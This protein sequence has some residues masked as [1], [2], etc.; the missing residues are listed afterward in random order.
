LLMAAAMANDPARPFADGNVQLADFFL[1]PAVCYH[2]YAQLAGCTLGGG[3]TLTARGYCFRNENAADLEVGRRQIEFEMRELILI[4]EAKWIEDRLAA[5]QLGV[6]T[7][8]RNCGLE[9]QWQPANDPFF[10]PQANGKAHMQR[11][12]GTKIELCLRD[13]LAVASINRHRTF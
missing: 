7:L 6:E 13:G 10:L 12:L 5:L 11:L 2:A 1:S 9:G 8:A 4:G 3:V